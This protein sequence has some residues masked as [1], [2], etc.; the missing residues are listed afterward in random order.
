MFQISCF[1]SLAD[2]TL[3]RQVPGLQPK[4]SR[5]KKR[6]VSNLENRTRPDLVERIL[7]QHARHAEINANNQEQLFSPNPVQQ[8]PT[9][10]QMSNTKA[11]G[12]Q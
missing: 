11:G 1:H 7:A 10:Q 3:R 6:G 8:S 2:L 12:S 5:H 4:R 9:A